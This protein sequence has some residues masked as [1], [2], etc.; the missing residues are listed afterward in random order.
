MLKK[1]SHLPKAFVTFDVNE[2]TK[3]KVDLVKYCKKKQTGEPLTANEI[4]A[5]L[6]IAR[7]Y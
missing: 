6:I 1:K 3:I 2:T 4:V 5:E 7:R